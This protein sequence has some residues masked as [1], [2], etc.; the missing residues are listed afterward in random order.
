MTTENDLQMTVCTK[1]KH[2]MNL[3]PG[4]VRT[5]VWYNHLCRATPLPTKFDP[6]DGKVKPY[7]VNDMGTEHFVHQRYQFCRY[8]ND[9]KCPKFEGAAA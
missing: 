8:I 4:S 2:F 7:R 5:G 1:C 3:E 6:Y 9:G